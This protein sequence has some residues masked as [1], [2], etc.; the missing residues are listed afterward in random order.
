MKA[1]TIPSFLFFLLQVSIT[2]VTAESATDVATSPFNRLFTKSSPDGTEIAQPLPTSRPGDYTKIASD[3]DMA[4]LRKILETAKKAELENI[5][6]ASSDGVQVTEPREPGESGGTEGSIQPASADGTGNQP[7]KLETLKPNSPGLL[8]LTSEEIGPQTQ[9]NIDIF[10]PSTIYQP[11]IVGIDPVGVDSS[12][13]GVSVTMQ[14]IATPNGLFVGDDPDNNTGT[15]SILLV[16]PASQDEEGV[17]KLAS[18]DG[19]TAFG[20][21][22]TESESGSLANNEPINESSSPMEPA[23]VNVTTTTQSGLTKIDELITN[24]TDSSSPVVPASVDEPINTNTTESGTHVSPA[25]EVS[26]TRSVELTGDYAP[27]PKKPEG[28]MTCECTCKFPSGEV[29]GKKSGGGRNIGPGRM[30]VPI[31]TVVVGRALARS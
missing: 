26:T 5:R 25:S 17:F 19:S 6:P 3:A 20:N 21:V 9:N 4:L 13:K 28:K 12:I 7:N 10:Q 15:G 22:T 14:D 18:T 1:L 29:A 31:V 16:V 2:A 11:D 27:K 23:S 24:G 8:V 30:M